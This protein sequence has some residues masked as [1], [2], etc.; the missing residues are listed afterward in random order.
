MAS[1]INPVAEGLM[2]A[3]EWTNFGDGTM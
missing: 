1:E 3:R 2:T